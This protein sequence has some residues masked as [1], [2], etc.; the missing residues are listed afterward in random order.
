[1]RW[2]VPAVCRIATGYIAIPIL[3]KPMVDKYPHP[4]MLLLQFVCCFAAALPLAV[5][6]HQHHIDCAACGPVG[7]GSP[8][9]GVPGLG[10]CDAHG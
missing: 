2:Y 4:T 7:R 8:Q 9:L 5:A 1:M 6:L 10:G 3:L